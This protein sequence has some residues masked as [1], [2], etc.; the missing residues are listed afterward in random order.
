MPDARHAQLQAFVLRGEIELKVAIFLGVRRQLVGADIDLAPL[1]ALADVPD[2]QQ[3]GAPGR[4]MVALALGLAE[5]LAADPF[6]SRNAVAVR[7]GEVELSELARAQLFAA[8]YR[9]FGRLARRIDLD[10][11]PLARKCK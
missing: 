5:P 8:L 3:A 11:S 6:V 9:R 4:E 7:A 10:G 2:R 1:E